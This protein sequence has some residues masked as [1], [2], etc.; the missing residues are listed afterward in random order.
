LAALGVYYHH[1]GVHTARNVARLLGLEAPGDIPV[2]RIEIT[3]LHVN[4]G[5]AERMGVTIPDE[6]IA[7]A[8]TVVE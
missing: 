8:K 6:V 2:Q 7:R 4:P 3:E 5:A 1:H